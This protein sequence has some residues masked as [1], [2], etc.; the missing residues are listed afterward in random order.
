MKNLD[1]FIGGAVCTMG[2]V[3]CLGRKPQITD[4]SPRSSEAPNAQV[5]QHHRRKDSRPCR[6]GKVDTQQWKRSRG[7]V[8]LSN[9]VI[10]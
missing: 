5:M 9:E 2:R 7:V 4:G 10:S 6:K 1:G 8:Q 3:W